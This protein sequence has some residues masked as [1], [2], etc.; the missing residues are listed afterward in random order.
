MSATTYKALK[1][2]EARVCGNRVPAAAHLRVEVVF[3][4]RVCPRAHRRLGA[5]RADDQL[6]LE[7][8]LQKH[9]HGAFFFLHGSVQG[10]QLPPQRTRQHERDQRGRR[11]ERHHGRAN[12]RKHRNGKHQLR[13]HGHEARDDGRHAA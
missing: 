8:F 1:K 7:R 10:L 9:A 6:V 3:L 13:G 4:Q 2:R 12:E 11:K 5:G